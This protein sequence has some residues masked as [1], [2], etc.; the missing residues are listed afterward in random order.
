[1]TCFPLVITY[2]NVSPSSMQMLRPQNCTSIDGGPLPTSNMYLP[3]KYMTLRPMDEANT[4]SILY[5]DPPDED[6]WPVTDEDTLPKPTY[7]PF[8]GFGSDSST[9]DSGLLKGFQKNEDKGNEEAPVCTVRLS[10]TILLLHSDKS[11]KLHSI[12]SCWRC[13]VRTLAQE[14]LQKYTA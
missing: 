13:L 1:M 10:N 4:V 5:F 8:V 6:P 3:W 2:T 9:L 14:E 12:L 7:K 11:D